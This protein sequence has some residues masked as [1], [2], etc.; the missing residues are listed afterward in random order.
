MFVLSTQGKYLESIF[1]NL[2]VF[3]NI[4]SQILY[5]TA[6]QKNFEILTGKYM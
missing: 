6:A 2:L 4:Y 1:E 5:K 3:R